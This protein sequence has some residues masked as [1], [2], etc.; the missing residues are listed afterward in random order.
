MNCGLG[1]VCVRNRTQEEVE[2]GI[3]FE[4]LRDLELNEFE[5]LDLQKLPKESRG[6][7]CLITQLVDLQRSKLLSCKYKVKDQIL[8]EL[9]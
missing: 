3:T 9:K 7:G 6:M 8:K 2:K 4:K 1:I 5:S